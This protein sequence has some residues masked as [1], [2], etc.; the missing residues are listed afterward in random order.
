M[1]MSEKIRKASEDL[2]ELE[3]KQITLLREK[4]RLNTHKQVKIVDRYG[5]LIYDI[6]FDFFWYLDLQLQRAQ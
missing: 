2:T 4:D 5:L 1:E 6:K 3:G